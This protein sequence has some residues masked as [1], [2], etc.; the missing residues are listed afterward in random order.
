M[1]TKSDVYSSGKVVHFVQDHL[2]QAHMGFDEVAGVVD[3]PDDW[4][5][6]D[7]SWVAVRLCPCSDVTHGLDWI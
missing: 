7:G 5:V 1:T 2:E 4:E 6:V 3:C